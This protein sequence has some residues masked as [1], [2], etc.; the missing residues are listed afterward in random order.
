MQWKDGRKSEN[1]EDRR[2]IRVSRGI[3]GGGIGTII[4]V[5]VALYFGVDPSILLNQGTTQDAGGPPGSVSRERPAEENRM[6]DFVSVVLADT[7]DT[8]HEL[9]RRSG[10]SYKEPKLVLFSD[11]VDSAFCPGLCHSPR[12]RPPCT[13]PPGHIGQGAFAAA[14]CGKGTGQRIVGKT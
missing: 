4:L 8:W 5:L 6:A 3:I 11:A 10:K 9:F 13:K 14:G 12:D 2:G 7:E 1:V